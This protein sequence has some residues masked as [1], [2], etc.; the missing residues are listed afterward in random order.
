L[1]IYIDPIIQAQTLQSDGSILQTPGHDEQTGLF[2]NP[3]G[4]DFESIKPEPTQNDARSALEKL[5]N[6]PKDFPFENDKSTFVAISAIL[7]ALIRRSIPTAP[8]HGFTAPKMAS[9]KSLLADVI[10]ADRNR[11]KQF[12]DVTS[13]K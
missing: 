13:R 10:G 11:K 12:Y 4:T 2:F 5:L 1:V 7:T 3:G 8:L 9:G 6:I